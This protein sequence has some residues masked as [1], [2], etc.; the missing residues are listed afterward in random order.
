IKPFKKNTLGMLLESA[1]QD[2]SVPGKGRPDWK[3]ESQA[4]Q[5]A[6]CAVIMGNILRIGAGGRQA[7]PGALLHAPV[8]AVLLAICLLIAAMP[9]AHAEEQILGVLHTPV[10]VPARAPLADPRQADAQGELDRAGLANLAGRQ[11][12]TGIASIR[13][14]DQ[15]GQTRFVIE[16][17]GDAA[18][19]FRV[20]TLPDPYR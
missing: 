18:A 16:L 7:G 11:A 17:D 9:P 1:R 14:G 15:A 10:S 8:L 6:G 4:S 2:R 5:E 12:G 3:S 20:F 19:N 13:L